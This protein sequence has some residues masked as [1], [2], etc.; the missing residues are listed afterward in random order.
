MIVSE[1]SCHPECP[2]PAESPPSRQWSEPGLEWGHIRHYL[3]VQHLQHLTHLR[4]FH[5]WCPPG[6]S[7]RLGSRSRQHRPRCSSWKPANIATQLWNFLQEFC[8]WNKISWNIARMESRN[9]IYFKLPRYLFWRYTISRQS[10]SLKDL[11]LNN[12]MSACPAQTQS[13]SRLPGAWLIAILWFLFI[14]QCTGS[15]LWL[16]GPVCIPGWLTLRAEWSAMEQLVCSV[17][18]ATEPASDTMNTFIMVIRICKKLSSSFYLHG[19]RDLAPSQHSRVHQLPALW[20]A[21]GEK[22]TK[23]LENN[24]YFVVNWTKLFNRLLKGS[25][26]SFNDFT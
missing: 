3:S 17:T 14:A 10:P 24:F 9:W 11:G 13:S 1:T 22:V 7:A 12:T 23:L 6:P 15:Q 8:A 5:T 19:L 21:N 4:R 25:L 20:W 18:S 26:S 2:A 16:L